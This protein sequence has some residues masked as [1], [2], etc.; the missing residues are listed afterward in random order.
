MDAE[1]KESYLQRDSAECKGDVRVHRSFS[2]IW[3]E[4]ERAE[5]DILGK[6][7]NRTTL[8]EPTN[9]LA[10]ATGIF[11]RKERKGLHE[12]VDSLE[13]QIVRMKHWLSGIV[14]RAWIGVYA[15]ISDGQKRV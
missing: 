9:E 7:L 12:Q 11:K 15:G 1:N 14:R 10:C 13:H 6:I 3:K 5:P 8:T 2:W 4:R